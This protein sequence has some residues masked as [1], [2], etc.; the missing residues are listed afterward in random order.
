M[1]SVRIKLLR[2]RSAMPKT[3]IRIPVSRFEVLEVC[4]VNIKT[5][6]IVEHYSDLLYIEVSLLVRL[7]HFISN[8]FWGGWI[9]Q[10]KKFDYSKQCVLLAH[11]V[12][13]DKPIPFFVRPT[14][15]L[16]NDSLKPCRIVNDQNI[17]AHR[18]AMNA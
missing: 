16:V 10:L 12:V 8:T 7:T 18:F 9:Q 14:F 13:K 3:P 2:Q 11:G 17:D 6:Q 4:P 15:V 1:K 5:G